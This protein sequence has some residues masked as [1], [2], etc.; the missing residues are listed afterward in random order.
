MCKLFLLQIQNERSFSICLKHLVN[1]G[2]TLFLPHPYWV[3]LA[4]YG[5]FVRLL[6][7]STICPL[8]VA[9]CFQGCL[10]LV[11]ACSECGLCIFRVLFSLF[12]SWS[13]FCNGCQP[14]FWDG[15]ERGVGTYIG[16]HRRTRARSIALSSA[17]CDL[18]DFMPPCIRR[19]RRVRGR[20]VDLKRW[21]CFAKTPE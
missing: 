2:T 8:L 3:R 15:S 19:R 14:L 17:D 12:I 20:K 16:I 7:M 21:S 10:F 6:S 18:C 1:L 13:R 9:R 11:T 5:R 4:H